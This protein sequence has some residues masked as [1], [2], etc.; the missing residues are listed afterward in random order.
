MPDN[1]IGIVFWKSVGHKML[2]KI[3]SKTV[4]NVRGP[5]IMPCNQ[6]EGCI[7]ICTQRERVTNNLIPKELQLLSFYAIKHL[8]GY[9]NNP[10]RGKET[11]FHSCFVFKRSPCSLFSMITASIILRF[12]ASFLYLLRTDIL[13]STTLPLY[14]RLCSDPKERK[15]YS[16]S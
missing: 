6:K 13:K 5:A 7:S 4:D 11:K 15:P 2:D 3:S 9:D 14:V 1:I 8:V 12:I 16:C 10:T